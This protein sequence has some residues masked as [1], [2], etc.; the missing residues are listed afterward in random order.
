M[1]QRRHFLG[2]IAAVCA[3]SG[4]VRQSLATTISKDTLNWQS[5]IIETLPLGRNK[6]APVVTSVS[7]QKTGSLLAIVGDNHYVGIYDM[8]RDKYVYNLDRHADWV[9]AAKFSPDGN[10]L[11]TAGNDRKLLIWNTANWAG[12]TMIKSHPEAIIDVAF[13]S[14]GSKI[15]TV[16]FGTK[17]R[18]YDT[19]SGELEKTLNCPC[20]DVHAVAFSKNDTFL[21][22]GG[23]SGFIRVWTPVDDRQIAHYKAHRQRIRSI[24]FTPQHEVLSCGDD[25]IVRIAN[26]VQT[27]ETRALPRHASKLYDVVMLGN[28]L[29]ATSGSDNQIH[30]WRMDDAYQVGSLKG[31]TGTVSSLDVS[32]FTLVSGSYDTH[33]RVWTMERQANL[34]VK[35]RNEFSNSGWNRKLK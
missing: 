6:R 14:D 24:E 33:V 23:R 3:M 20:N 4:S 32:G 30:V 25:Q 26:P 16:G 15:A 2:S 19:R 34:I 35:P 13:N 10:L 7:I 12:P 8:D 9:R 11:A 1:I 27:T 5:R 21:A 22:A 31:H 18:L 17:L 28:G 29:V